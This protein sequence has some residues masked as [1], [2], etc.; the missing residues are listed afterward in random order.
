M[1]LRVWSDRFL[2]VVGGDRGLAGY[3]L[4]WDELILRYQDL[5]VGSESPKVAATTT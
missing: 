4:G 5:I 3:V 2:S 1:C